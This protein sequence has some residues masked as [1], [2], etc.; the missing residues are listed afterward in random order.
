M[1][2]CPQSSSS[3]AIS[4]ELKPTAIKLTLLGLLA[5]IYFTTASALAKLPI[6]ISSARLAY[7]TH[8]DHADVVRIIFCHCNE[9]V[10]ASMGELPY[11]HHGAISPFLSPKSK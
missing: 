8:C 11:S 4:H 9:S 2:Y 10:D 6:I 7:T 3:S 1:I 5:V